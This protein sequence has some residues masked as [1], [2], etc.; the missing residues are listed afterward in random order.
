MPKAKNPRQCRLTFKVNG[1]VKFSQTVADICSYVKL[2][3]QDVTVEYTVECDN[4]LATPK[5]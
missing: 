3:K 4:C 1:V 5:I 2:A